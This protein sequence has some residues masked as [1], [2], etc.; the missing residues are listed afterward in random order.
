MVCIVQW[1]CDFPNFHG[2]GRNVNFH[3]C[4]SSVS[5]FRNMT[6]HRQSGKLKRSLLDKPGMS[7]AHASKPGL[8]RLPTEFEHFESDVILCTVHDMFNDCFQS[9]GKTF[10]SFTFPAVML[11]VEYMFRILECWAQRNC[12]LGHGCLTQALLTPKPNTKYVEASHIFES[13]WFI[14]TV[15]GKRGSLKLSLGILWPLT[16]DGG[17]EQSR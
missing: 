9:S 13:S 15:N 3:R 12:A 7:I 8:G 1:L 11:I 10:M 14:W 5:S 2:E 4:R 6:S 17:E 16:T